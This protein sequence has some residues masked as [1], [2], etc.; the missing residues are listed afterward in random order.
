MSDGWGVPPADPALRRRWLAALCWRAVDEL[1]GALAVL[2]RLEAEGE[3][4]SR[5][6]NASLGAVRLMLRVKARHLAVSG[7]GPAASPKSD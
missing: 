3:G 5:A 6:E 1:D 4:L 7:P 2:Q